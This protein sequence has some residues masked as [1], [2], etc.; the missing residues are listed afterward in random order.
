M[1]PALMNVHAHLVAAL[2]SVLSAVPLPWYPPD[3]P[4][5]ETAAERADRL[6]MLSEETV[7]AAEGIM[8]SHDW[9]EAS[10]LEVEDLVAMGAVQLVREAYLSWESHSGKAWP[11]RP[12]PRGDHQRAICLFQLHANASQIPIKRWRPFE[13]HQWESLEGLDVAST[14]W[15]VRSGLLVLAY[16]GWRC[17]KPLGGKFRGN[18]P[19]DEQ[20]RETIVAHIMRENWTP[21]PYPV[22][23]SV[24]GH[25]DARVRARTFT[26]YRRRI[27]AHVAESVKVERILDTRM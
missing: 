2:L 17:R 26:G 7:A 27:L 23:C 24:I 11:G 5:P 3:A 1:G 14:R 12:K 21:L 13:R 4:M 16:H 15:C 18:A 8:V 20:A 22:R 19:V 25:D 9:H 6:A 10:G